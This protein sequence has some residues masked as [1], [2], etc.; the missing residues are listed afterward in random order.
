MGIG[1]ARST[2]IG[3]LVTRRLRS[4]RQKADMAAGASSRATVALTVRHRGTHQIGLFDQ[5]APNSPS[6][7]GLQRRP[8]FRAA[9]RSPE[10]TSRHSRG[11]HDNLRA[12]AMPNGTFG[13]FASMIGIRVTSYSTPNA[14]TQAHAFGKKMCG[15]SGQWNGYLFRL[16]LDLRKSFF[17]NRE[18]LF[19]TNPDQTPS[20]SRTAAGEIMTSFPTDESNA[21]ASKQVDFHAKLSARKPHRQ[22]AK[23]PSP[24]RGWSASRWPKIRM[25]MLTHAQKRVLEFL[26]QHQ[27]DTGGISPTF[28][29]MAD[30][31]GLK[32]KSGGS[33]CS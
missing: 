17:H 18:K 8:R 12:H 21:E 31:A 4:P 7:N 32:S 16:A 9:A 10:P 29:E 22:N 24:G 13:C 5:E 6:A 27:R 1:S 26:I 2:A 19:S 28:A 11:Q 33:A 30:A 25:A 23:T 20:G 14:E 3:L 15:Q